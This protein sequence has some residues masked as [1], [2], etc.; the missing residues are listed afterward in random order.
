M[1]L[2]CLFCSPKITKQQGVPTAVVLE[3]EIGN[4]PVQ[5]RSGMSMAGN[6]FPASSS[7]GSQCC[8]GSH[9]LALPPVQSIVGLYSA[10][11][12]ND[13]LQTA[14]GNR[15]ESHS[16]LCSFRALFFIPKYTG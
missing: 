2:L 6:H 7:Q 10:H 4:F 9:R 14:V 13:T 16:D 12:I 11:V 1:A 5:D 15:K 8:A 3:F